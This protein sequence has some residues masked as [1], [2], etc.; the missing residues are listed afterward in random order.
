MIIWGSKARQKQIATGTFFCPSCRV[1]SP[2]SHIRWARYF[3]LYFI[4][5]F[6]TQT[7]AETVK[8]N[9]CAGEFKPTI[10]ALSNEEIEAALQPWACSACGNKNPSS[11]AACLA[12]AS[13]RVVRTEARANEASA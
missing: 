10:L 9:A 13:A 11:E 12:C 1:T 5:L 2:Y 6:P 4:P 7:L 3:T 8:C